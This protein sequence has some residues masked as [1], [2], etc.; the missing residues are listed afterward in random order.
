MFRQE[1]NTRQF[2]FL[3][4]TVGQTHLTAKERKL[5]MKRLN[6]ASH[7]ERLRS[8]RGPDRADQRRRSPFIHQLISDHSFLCQQRHCHSC[9]CSPLH[10][11][12]AS[13]YTFNSARQFD[14]SEQKWTLLW[15][16][17]TLTFTEKLPV[18]LSVSCSRRAATHW[19]LLR[20]L[21]RE[22]R[23]NDP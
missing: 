15:H 10:I 3:I 13:V 5:S 22:T 9:C 17:S 7:S 8:R 20:G 6:Q 14:L 18:L 19:S 12:L 11:H 16:L 2:F 1:I 23:N 4:L 21:R